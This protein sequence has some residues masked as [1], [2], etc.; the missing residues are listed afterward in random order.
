MGQRR[1]REASRYQAAS[2]SPL[3]DDGPS[4]QVVMSVKFGARSIKFETGEAGIVV[5]SKDKLRAV[6][7]TLSR[8]GR[9]V[10][11]PLHP[12]RQNRVYRQAALGR[13]IISRPGNGRAKVRHNR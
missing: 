9:G 6:I 2:R 7:D 13:L 1:Q 10:G 8:P 12:G 5:P 4:G 11:R 3:V